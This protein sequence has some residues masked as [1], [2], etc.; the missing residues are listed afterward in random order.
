VRDGAVAVRGGR[1][2]HVGPAAEVRAAAPDLTVADLGGDLL[3]PGLVDAH[4][5]L[6]W[7]LLEGLLPPGD[8]AA[9]L[10]RLLPMRARMTAS[11]H[12]AAARYGALQALR[13]GTTTL[14]DLGPVGAGAAALAESGQRGLVLLEAFGRHEGRAATEAAAAIS[15]R[16]AELDD[17]CGPRVRAGVSP[18]APYTVGPALWRALAARADLG[19]RPWGT[20]LAESPH[21]LRAVR[22]GG[23]ALGE[24]LAAAGH[25]PG[26]WPAADGDEGAEGV[27]PRLD[28]AGAL[29][30]GMVAAHCVEVGAGD[31]GV[32][33]ARG[34]A[35]A[36]CPRSNAHLRCGRAPLEELRAAGV[37]VA[38]GTDSAA[39][40]GDHDPRAEA[41]A[42]RVAHAGVHEVG[43]D[44]LLRM[45][46]C[47]A[48]AVL[49]MAGEVGVLAPGAR[50]DLVALAP[51]A[52]DDARDPTAVALDP[53]TTVH[54]V[55][56]G[57]E[58]L[59]ADGTP[60][61]L[62]HEGILARAREARG[63]L[64]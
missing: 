8:F 20:H 39:S 50:A 42:C 30:P 27:V 45:I 1:I 48:A 36:H 34:V 12:L 35:V 51:A 57:G 21:E 31:A 56:I 28:G 13:H 6:E 4:T 2:A 22:D 47:D 40:G 58:V 26:R 52:H 15:A 3:L 64:C 61:R 29:R 5:H 16:L 33:A 38:L 18:H 53:A 60:T 32:L 46:T 24:V 55:I 17:A 19:G 10:G 11:D 62:D 37:A 43:D 44:E 54:R 63:R 41:R 14:A 25:V 23:G 7:S 59:V 49:G 9:W